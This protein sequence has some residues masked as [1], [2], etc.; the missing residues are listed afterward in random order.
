MRCWSCSTEVPMKPFCRNCGAADPDPE[1]R[2]VAIATRLIEIAEEQAFLEAQLERL[3]SA[4][5]SSAPNSVTPIPD[6]PR[7]T[8]PISPSAPVTVPSAP[9]V[10]RTATPNL[11]FDINLS[12]AAVV[13]MIGVVLL[14]AASFVSAKENPALLSLS[15]GV[16]LIAL[17]VEAIAATF[18]TV[19]LSRERTT[20]ADAFGALTWSASLSLGMLA[21]VNVVDGSRPD[22]WT[23]SI[24]FAVGALVV[25]LAGRQLP[26]T[27]FFGLGTVAFGIVH[28]AY[29]GLNPNVNGYQYLLEVPMAR[30]VIVMIVIALVASSALWVTLS[31][32]LAVLTRAETYLSF[33]TIAL[34]LLFVLTTPLPTVTSTGS[35]LLA[36]LG[37]LSIAI[38]FFVGALAMRQRD[39]GVGAATFFGLT[40]GLIALG[41]VASAALG[42]IGLVT[43]FPGS[44]LATVYFPV[45]FGALALGVA[46]VALRA[47]GWALVCSFLACVALVP[48]VGALAT[49]LRHELAGW[50]GGDGRSALLHWQTGWFGR[51]VT[52]ADVPI[53]VLVLSTAILASALVAFSRSASLSLGLQRVL[54]QIGGVVVVTG[55]VAVAMRYTDRSMSTTIFAT[56]FAVLGVIA[57]VTSRFVR[58]EARLDEWVPALLLGG[59]LLASIY[60]NVTES[61]SIDYV[62]RPG[63]LT[64]ALLGVV[65]FGGVATALR[66]PTTWHGLVGWAVSL[67]ALHG[68]FAI[69]GGSRAIWQ[70]ALVTL[71]SVYLVAGLTTRQSSATVIDISSSSGLL[72]GGGLI[73]FLQF[74]AMSRFPSE[75]F[76]ISL[77]LLSLALTVAVAQRR[78]ASLPTPV[79]ITPATAAGLYLT[80][81]L[82]SHDYA[83]AW[84]LGGAVLLV[85]ILALPLRDTK[86]SWATFGPALAF[87]FVTTDIAVVRD[88]STLRALLLGVGAGVVALAGYLYRRSAAIE[89]G[90]VSTAVAIVS[91]GADPSFQNFSLGWTIA[92]TAVASFF[93]L[94]ATQRVASSRQ[95]ISQTA[96]IV[97]LSGA[98]SFALALDVAMHSRHYDVA[99]VMSSVALVI[100]AATRRLGAHFEAR[101][102]LFAGIAGGVIWC[103]GMDYI[104]ASGLWLLG[105]GAV[106]LALTWRSDEDRS[107]WNE[108]G[109]AL[110]LIMIPANYGALTGSSVSA[111][112][113]IGGAIVLVVLG[114]QLKKRAVFDVAVATF[115]LLSIARL[116]QVVSDKGRWIVAVVVGIALVANGFWRETRNKVDRDDSTV[117]SWYRSLQ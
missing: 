25:G 90:A 117:T 62:Y 38:P 29:F 115:A 67:P 30:G 52:V 60:H 40:S 37:L 100:L 104:A 57:F 5:A 8:E 65:S 81:Q 13:T 33:I 102:V 15:H 16:R 12:P 21:T 56:T 7:T 96:S 49:T 27:R 83:V 86:N 44:H 35:G 94:A 87:L 116:S 39:H 41:V 79:L 54:R 20:L 109:P 46:F 76:R 74:A 19:Y 103:R 105:T 26:L 24:P 77:L 70:I 85:T 114:V 36:F 69:H 4:P 108:W 112:F 28:L 53:M 10:I 1:T 34:L 50:I 64:M 9:V 18:A 55:A 17:V 98:V 2:R 22:L 45:I 111:A 23:Y 42:H 92:A 106:L 73:Y 78:G 48:S 88:P 75:P 91:H 61:G 95:L 89:A 71:G 47:R 107:S 58:D 82:W 31:P 93:V 113:A 101:F 80:D 84:A 11:P 99:L 63:G 72:I 51:G 14:A 59:G 110:A 6:A 97:G 3:G 43:Q 32:R 68:I 66:R